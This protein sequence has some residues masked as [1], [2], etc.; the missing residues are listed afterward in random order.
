[1]FQPEVVKFLL[2]LV[3]FGAGLNEKFVV[4]E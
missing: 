4:V 1:L 2:K 3:E